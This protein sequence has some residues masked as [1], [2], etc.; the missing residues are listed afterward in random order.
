MRYF[1]S[2]R[3]EPFPATRPHSRAAAVV[4][5]L[6]LV[7]SDIPAFR[8]VAGRH[9]VFIRDGDRGADVAERLIRAF[10]RRKD[11]MYRKKVLSQYSWDVVF[12]ER[13]VPAVLRPASVWPTS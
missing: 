3:R 8:E 10:Q 1:V 12:K 13:I 5:G 9:A 6:L 11:L 2:D 4:A 7:V